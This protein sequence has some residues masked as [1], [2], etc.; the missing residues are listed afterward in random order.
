MP[1]RIADL[2]RM[3]PKAMIATD[4]ELSRYLEN[5]ASGL[6][7]CG[8]MVIYRD[9]SEIFFVA[10]CPDW[11]WGGVFTRRLDEVEEGIQ[12]SSPYTGEVYEIYTK[13]YRVLSAL[14]FNTLDW[15]REMRVEAEEDWAEIRAKKAEKD[16][17]LALEQLRELFAGED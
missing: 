16:S 3:C 11:K 9:V 8:E 10:K 4:Y 12:V 13:C 2:K 7:S 6:A 5:G 14:G 1:L 17:N 15:S